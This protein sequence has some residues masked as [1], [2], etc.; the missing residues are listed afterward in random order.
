[1]T[2]QN[3]ELLKFK[4]GEID[5]LTAKG[6]DYPGLKKDEASGGFTVHRLGPNKGSSFLVFNQN[7]GKDSATGKPY[8]TPSKSALFC[9]EKFRKAIAYALDKQSMIRIVMNGLGYPQWSPMAPSEGRFFKS[10]VQEYPYDMIKAKGML[11]DLGFTDRNGDGIIEDSSGKALEFSF[12]INSGNV[13]RAKIAE[14][15]RK[16][17]SDLGIDVHF[18]QVEFNTLIQKIDNPPYEWDVILLGLTGGDEPHFGKNVWYSSGSLHMWY[19][20]QMKPATAWETTIDSIFDTGVKELDFDKRKELYDQ[21]QVIAADKLPLIYTVLSEN[22]Q[23][24][25]NK[26]GNIN[27]SL[28]GG[29]LSNLEYIYV[30]K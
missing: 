25:W 14:I 10:D 15:I 19:P 28:N 5:F 3:A 24:L 7:L 8:V 17:L 13:V 9:N 11:A 1:V 21:W 23:C 2:D 18:Q 30:K 16:D 27:P 29:L 20:S 6:E 4:R 26:F 22:I 12:I